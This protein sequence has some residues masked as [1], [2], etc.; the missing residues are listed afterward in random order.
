MEKNK[1]IILLALIVTA[2]FTGIAEARDVKF[3]VELD[4]S[5]VTIGD[6]AELGLSFYGTQGMPAPDIGQISGLDIRYMGPSTMLT[7]IN[8]QVSSSVT[9]RY[10]IQPLKVGKF[11]IGPFSFRYKGDDY[12][13]N[14][15]FL[16]AVEERL[17][18]VQPAMTAQQIKEE[19]MDIEDRV[20]LKLEIGKTMAYVNELIP[21]A[22]KLYS[23]IPLSEIQLP[24]FD[25]E[26]FSKAE[27]KDAKQYRG[28]IDGLVYD[29]LEFKTTMLGTRPGTYRIGPA[30]IKCNMIKRK[31][32]RG[33]SADDFFGDDSYRDSFFD[34]FFTRYERKPIELKSQD[35]QLIISPLPAE[36]CPQDFSGAVGDYQFIYS[37][38]PTKLKAGDPV[39]VRMTINGTGNFNTVFSPKIGNTDN[40]RLYEPQVKTEENSKTFTQVLIPESENV[41]EVPA[42]SFSYFDTNKKEYR[43]IVQGPIALQVEKAKEEAPSMVVGPPIAL[44]QVPPAEE[45]L[46]RDIIYIK[47][48]PGRLLKEDYQIYKSK[49]FLILIVVPLV[50]LAALYFVEGR[51]NRLARDSVYA[52][53]VQAFRVSKKGM[54]ELKNKL[55]SADTKAFYETLFKVLQDYL[56]NRVHVPAGGITADIVDHVL[57]AKGIDYQVLAKARRL[58][59]TCDR[60]RF[61]SLA[62][63]RVKMK[64]DLL[65]LK[66]IIEYFERKKI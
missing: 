3:E 52:G 57:A 12:S 21:V 43:R 5:K 7:V 9:H 33:R 40:F 26:G 14:M 19:A 59:E 30:K 35:A 63:D 18:K 24:T 29:V 48:S 54:S 16:E 60:V 8:G 13:S 46:T 15:A 1:Y 4:R 31:S 55:K 45:A 17:P 32:L 23:R 22:V 6:T 44:S 51:K 58:F 42:A 10:K 34:D 28:T 53:R 61:S 47:E 2:A 20:F 25:Q 56:G 36:N 39:T 27:F 50:F 66:E 62:A 41:K 49:A 37:A 38:S 65:E 11:Q 64:D